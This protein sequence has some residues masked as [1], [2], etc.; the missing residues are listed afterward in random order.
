V[1]QFP[2]VPEDQRPKT[3]S[4]TLTFKLKLTI[5]DEYYCHAIEESRRLYRLYMC[6]LRR[7]KRKGSL[8][9]ECLNWNG[10]HGYMMVNGIGLGWRGGNQG[11]RRSVRADTPA[12]RRSE[13]LEV[14]AR[15]NYWYIVIPDNYF[16][17]HNPV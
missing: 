8:D 10:N 6:C 4:I 15:C 14:T 16:Q 9:V 2:D 7:K 1:C 17:A 3:T 11:R 5:E 12:G 13:S